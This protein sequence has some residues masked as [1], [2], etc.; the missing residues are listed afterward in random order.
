M[1]IQ[2]WPFLISRNKTYEYRAVVAPQ[3]LCDVDLSDILTE[4]SGGTGVTDRGWVVYR[5]MRGLRRGDVTLIFRVVLA[6]ERHLGLRSKELLYDQHYRPI[7]LTEGLVLE[8]VGLDVC[9]TDD[10]FNFIHHRMQDTFRLFWESIANTPK[11]YSSQS[12][13]LKVED[14]ESK[15]L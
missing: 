2:G 6:T 14:D 9:I 8:G 5:Q 3:F 15:Y 7:Y 4:A 10:N 1:N 12:L 13:N 11:T